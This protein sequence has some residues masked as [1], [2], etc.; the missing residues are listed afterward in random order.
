LKKKKKKNCDLS[1]KKILFV[2]NLYNR[3]KVDGS[4]AFN[5][6]SSAATGWKVFYRSGPTGKPAGWKHMFNRFHRNFAG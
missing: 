6:V 4:K 2:K 3:N 5:P 1:C